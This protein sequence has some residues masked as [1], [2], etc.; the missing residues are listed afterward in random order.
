MIRRLIVLVVALRAA[1]RSSDTAETSRRTS[2]RRWLCHSSCHKRLRKGLISCRTSP[3]RL[4]GLRAYRNYRRQDA[5]R[6]RW[7]RWWHRFSRSRTL[8]HQ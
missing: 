3:S 8:L 6:S 7:I 5:V 4:A 2:T 1:P